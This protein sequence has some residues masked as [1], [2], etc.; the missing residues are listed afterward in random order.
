MGVLFVADNLTAPS[1][2]WMRRMLD[3]LTEHVAVLTDDR[4][5]GPRYS[6][7]LPVVMLKNDPAAIYRRGLR[8]AGFSISCPPKVTA[9]DKLHSAVKRPEVSAVLIHFL[10]RAAKY[11]AVWRRTTKP[12]F[13]HCHGYDVTWDLRFQEGW[14]GRPVHP[15]DYVD[16]VRAL[17]DNVNFIA[18][19]Q[20]ARARL[21]EIGSANNRITVK[22]LGVKT[23]AEAPF[24]TDA[25]NGVN[26]LY[27][28]R[29]IDCKGPDLLIQAFERA[30][31]QDLKGSLTLAGDGPMR[32][33]CELLRQRS[34]YKDRI[35]LLGSVNGETGEMLRDRAD[36][37]SSHNCLGSVSRQEEA[38]GV[39]FVEAMAAAL[40][41]VSTR[42]ASL[43]EI[44][45][46]GR[47]GILVEP[48]DI[49]AH[50]HAL[51]RLARDRDLRI[52][53]GLDG[54]RRARD[55]FSIEKETASLRQILGLERPVPE[56][57]REHP[58]LELVHNS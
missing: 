48:G 37:F 9:L 50:A 3:G 17:P 7:R 40:P 55:L 35:T 34:P 57:R 46:D 54:W 32:L 42:N 56:V 8:R 45:E 13:V 38:F 19:S 20:E 36:I 16:R 49:D 12:V 26:I 52:Q 6:E 14:I 1:H 39:S 5:P 27:L 30:S 51:L 2:L 33:T 58:D 44:I 4:D 29:L 23:P 28:G 24:R 21:L 15:S 10:T 18:N 53:M 22:Y 47:Q 25:E 43:P 41:V 11:E 31:D